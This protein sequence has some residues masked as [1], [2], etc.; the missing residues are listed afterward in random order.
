MFEIG[1]SVFS[2]SLAKSVLVWG[3]P[4]S[5]VWDPPVGSLCPSGVGLQ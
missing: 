5:P 1:C 3:A 2:V 4:A